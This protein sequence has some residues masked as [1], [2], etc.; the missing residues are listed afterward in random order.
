MCIVLTR[1][2]EENSHVLSQGHSPSCLGRGM[3][4]MEASIA[5]SFSVAPLL[6]LSLLYILIFEEI[7]FSTWFFVTLS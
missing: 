1:S 3:L 6:I 4:I 5:S 7:Q 2:M